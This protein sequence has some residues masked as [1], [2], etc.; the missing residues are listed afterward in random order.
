M[1]FLTYLRI[2]TNGAASAADRNV[3]FEECNVKRINLSFLSLLISTQ[4]RNNGVLSALSHIVISAVRYKKR[5]LVIWHSC[6]F[7]CAVALESAIQTHVH[8]MQPPSHAPT[9]KPRHLGRR[10]PGQ[11]SGCI[12]PS[13]CFPDSD[14]S[15]SIRDAGDVVVCCLRHA[16]LAVFF[17]IP[18]A[19]L[20]ATDSSCPNSLRIS[21]NSK[22]STSKTCWFE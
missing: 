17:D 22:H 7:C 19:A 15:A 5:T 11:R 8:N 21:F 3:Q 12:V 18:S 4:L 1:D 13:L 10:A 6:Q 20:S 2:Q 9:F 14:G 16:F